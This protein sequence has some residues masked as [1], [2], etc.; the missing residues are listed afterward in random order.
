MNEGACASRRPA[1]DRYRNARGN[2]SRPEPTPRQGVQRS[3]AGALDGSAA[4]GPDHEKPAEHRHL[5]ARLPL[6]GKLETRANQHDTPADAVGTPRALVA[7]MANQQDV[8]AGRMGNGER[9]GSGLASK[10]HEAAEQVKGAVSGQLEQ[11]KQRAESAKGQAAER[12]RRVALELRHVGET[13]QT[14]DEFAARLAQ[15]ASG[16]IDRVAGYISSADVR[17]LRSDAENFART[18]PAV[19]FGGAFLLGLAAGRFFKSS[20]GQSNGGSRGLTM[21]S[22]SPGLGERRPLTPRAGEAPRAAETGRAQKG[23]TP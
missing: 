6:E 8:S 14:D 9:G 19:F 11:A 16:T 12:V 3:R 2:L 20:G 22:T 23:F 10:T 17:Q 4:L 15:R 21:G 1:T 5:L 13:L 18:R 7:E